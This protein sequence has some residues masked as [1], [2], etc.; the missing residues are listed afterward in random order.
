MFCLDDTL[1]RNELVQPVA[2]LDLADVERSLVVEP[3]VVRRRELARS[4]AGFAKARDERA[5]E[6][7]H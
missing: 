1:D 4:G 6:V 7:E 5:L 3:Y 2:A